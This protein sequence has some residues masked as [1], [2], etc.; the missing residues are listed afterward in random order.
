MNKRKQLTTTILIL[1]GISALVIIISTSLASSRIAQTLIEEEIKKNLSLSEQAARL[2]EKEIQTIEEKVGLVTKFPQIQSS[3]SDVCNQKLAEI[4]PYLKPQ[5]DNMT[6]FNTK[7]TL[8]CA[9]AKAAIGYVLTPESEITA[10]IKNPQHPAHLSRS[11]YSPTSEQYVLYLTLP[12]F[13]SNGTFYGIIGGVTYLSYIADRYLSTIELGEGGYVTLLDDDGTYLYHPDTRYIGKKL[14]SPEIVAFGEDNSAVRNL[15]DVALEAS[16]NEESGNLRYSLMNKEMLSVYAPAHVFPG[17]TWTVILTQP[18]ATILSGIYTNEGLGGL[19][20]FI[21]LSGLIILTLI[22]FSAIT[23]AY[24]IRGLFT[25]LARIGE[26]AEKIGQGNLD[27]EVTKDLVRT[28]DE[29]GQLARAVQKMANELKSSYLSLENKVKERTEALNS[30]TQELEK[31]NS[32]LVG[33][34]LKMIELKEENAELNKK[35]SDLKKDKE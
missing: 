18:V 26:V 23:L 27:V 35:L 22:I 32:F 29:F 20:I 16:R 17:R 15:N 24:V 3:N 6:R 34:E 7:L 19:N 21:F 33:R 8:D 10:L 5:V 14:D 4:A 2:L 9:I 1:A 13:T 11:G 12:V 25:P 28:E 31:T 30:R